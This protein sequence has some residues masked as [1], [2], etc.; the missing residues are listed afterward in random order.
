MIW[1]VLYRLKSMAHVDCCDPT[2]P[3]RQFPLLTTNPLPISTSRHGR[4]SSGRKITLLCRK[5]DKNKKYSQRSYRPLVHCN[6]L[7]H[8]DN[9]TQSHRSLEHCH[10]T[11]NGRQPATTHKK[12]PPVNRRIKQS[13][14]I[15]NLKPFPPHY[16]NQ[17]SSLQQTKRYHFDT[18]ENNC[19]TK[20]W[21]EKQEVLTAILSLPGAP[22]NDEKRP[23]AKHNILPL[24]NRRTSQTTESLTTAWQYCCHVYHHMGWFECRNIVFSAF[25][26]VRRER[27]SVMVFPATEKRRSEAAEVHILSTLLEFTFHWWWPVIT[28]Q[29]SR[30][31]VYSI[32]I[33]HDIFRCITWYII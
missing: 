6:Y 28:Q 15:C 31:G 18:K 30:L 22:P 16:R 19:C 26:S 9:L 33:Y 20:K 1:R 17:Y 27:F 2:A 21:D 4:K 8:N 7:Q 3:P 29:M 13:T 25:S 24:D 32:P 11:R 12:V 14:A 5:R 23:A 10:R